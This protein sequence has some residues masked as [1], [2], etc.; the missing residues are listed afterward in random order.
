MIKSYEYCFHFG[1][2]VAFTHN[3]L[4][5]FHTEAIYITRRL[6]D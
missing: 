2:W 4:D 1:N 6:N 5:Y 3:I